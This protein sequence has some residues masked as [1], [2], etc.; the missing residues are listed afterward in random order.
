MALPKSGEPL[1]RNLELQGRGNCE[2]DKGQ[3]R[4]RSPR[5]SRPRRAVVVVGGP[6]R[7]KTTEKIEGTVVDETASP[8]PGSW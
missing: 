4:E 6:P 1:L 5:P 3:Y 8:C 7:P 2:H